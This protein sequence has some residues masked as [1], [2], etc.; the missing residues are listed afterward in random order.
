METTITVKDEIVE[1]LDSL[2]LEELK[3]V[4]AFTRRVATKTPPGIPGE[5]L[6]ARAREINFPPEDLAEIERAI[7]E[8]CERIDWI[9]AKT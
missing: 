2:S 4:L 7:E 8:D 5:V 9:T 1:A 3:A 6:I